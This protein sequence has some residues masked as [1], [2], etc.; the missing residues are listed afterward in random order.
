MS[1]PCV[2]AQ[3]R[4]WQSSTAKQELSKRQCLT[5]WFPWMP[6][7]SQLPEAHTSIC[8]CFSTR[9]APA[10][11]KL[12]SGHSHLGSAINGL[13][14]LGGSYL[15]LVSC[16]FNCKMK[17]LHWVVPMDFPALP[18]CEFYRHKIVPISVPCL[19]SKEEYEPQERWKDGVVQGR[20]G[21][22]TELEL[23]FL[24]A[25]G[26]CFALSLMSVHCHTSER[27]THKQN[28]RSSGKPATGTA[29]P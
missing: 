8:I 17:G 24:P 19:A 28:P 29:D 26:P 14:D 6:P 22:R 15:T 16:F 1:I 12:G 25:L 10:S 20:A 13:C 21:C 11:L 4:V 27:S 7:R 2:S 23:H 18:V 9:I 3:G 5:R